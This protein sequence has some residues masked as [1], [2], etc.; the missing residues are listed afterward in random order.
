MDE[1]IQSMA[2]AVKFLLGCIGENPDREGLLSTPTR[3]AKALLDL[4]VGYRE[5]IDTIVNRALFDEAHN[6][7]VLVRDITISSLCEHH[8]L[9]FTGKVG[10]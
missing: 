6:Q 4:T 1:Q 7:I 9:P 2:G 8:I 3:Y 10:R 5:D